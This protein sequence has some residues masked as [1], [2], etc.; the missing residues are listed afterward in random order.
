LTRRRPSP[1]SGWQCRS[2]AQ[3]SRKALHLGNAALGA[4]EMG[5]AGVDAEANRQNS[6]SHRFAARPS[7]SGW[8]GV[9]FPE[10]RNLFAN[11]LL[12]VDRHGSQNV[13]SWQR[14]IFEVTRSDRGTSGGIFRCRN[15]PNCKSVR[16]SLRRS[17][18]LGR[19]VCLWA[20]RRLSSES[21]SWIPTGRVFV[22]TGLLPSL[23][24]RTAA[25]LPSASPSG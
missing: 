18:A 25:R 8:R 2:N 22:S 1:G 14:T 7:P 21:L 3:N 24:V 10:S 20:W 16:I 4:G 12:A 19:Q 9:P 11:P 17:T 15:C 6:G 23:R 5:L 13:L